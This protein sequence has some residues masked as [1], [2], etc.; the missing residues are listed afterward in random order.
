M[1]RQKPNTVEEQSPT[2]A[3]MNGFIESN[4]SVRELYV[5]DRGAH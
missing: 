5:F 3:H 4:C 1:L 2:L